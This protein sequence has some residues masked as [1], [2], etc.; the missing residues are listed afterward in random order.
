MSEEALRRAVIGLRLA[1]RTGE[2]AFR[3]TLHVASQRVPLGPF[4]L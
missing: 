1:R 2:C 4:D 3:G